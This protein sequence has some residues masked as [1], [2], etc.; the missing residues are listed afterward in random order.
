MPIWYVLWDI[1]SF[2]FNQKGEPYFLETFGSKSDFDLEERILF[3]LSSVRTE[4]DK[5]II[6]E[7]LRLEKL[8]SDTVSVQRNPLQSKRIDFSDWFTFTIDGA[9]AKDLDDAISLRINEAWNYVLAVHIADVAEYVTE[10]SNLD[11]EAYTRATS[12]YTPGKVI[13]ML[14]ESLSNHLCS[15]H[16]GTPKF[17]LSCV[18]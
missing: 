13:P 4:F 3:Y 7:W 8:H 15:L 10:W 2:K 18:M 16:P 6:D 11:R 1:I 5:N 14:P 17:T 12:I 9:D